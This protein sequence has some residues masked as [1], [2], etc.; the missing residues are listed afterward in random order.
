M[1]KE[2]RFKSSTSEVWVNAAHLK[3]TMNASRPMS[4]LTKQT[5]QLI[6]DVSDSDAL[7]HMIGK[8]VLSID[9]RDKMEDLLLLEGTPK[10]GK[11]QE[12]TMKEI[13]GGY[14]AFGGNPKGWKSQEMLH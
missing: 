2:L 14:V 7:R 9:L 4:L 11:S 8:H 3:T 6:K 10:E 1:L 5:I 13:D 12:K